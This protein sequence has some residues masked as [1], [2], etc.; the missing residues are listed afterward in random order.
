MRPFAI[1]ALALS[2]ASAGFVQGFW[3][4]KKPEEWSARE[5]EKLLVDSPWAKSRT[6]GNVLIE[7]IGDPSSVEGRE[8]NPWIA[9]TARFWSARPVREAFVRQLRLAKEF[10]SLPPEK[11]TSAE[12]AHARI[13]AEEFS[14]RIVVM[15]VYST[16]VESYRRDLARHWQTRPAALWVMD[17]FLIS[18]FGRIPPLGV[19]VVPGEGGQFEL[20]F[21]RAVDGRPVVGPADKSISLEFVHPDMG[22]LRTERVHLD[23]KVKDMILDGQPV[24]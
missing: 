22:V 7:Q 24:F 19:R 3:Q 10:R 4:K 16:N 5:C 18:G 2:L 15:I 21:P 23:F 11:K 20:L 6:F 8:G 14:D 13:L 17:T 9:Y 1:V 12:E